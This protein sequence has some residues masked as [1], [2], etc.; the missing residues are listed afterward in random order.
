MKDENELVE[1]KSPDLA[2][3]EFELQAFPVPLQW[4]G[5]SKTLTWSREPE[6]PPDQKILWNEMLAFHRRMIMDHVG[7]HI[8][9][10][11]AVER[12]FHADPQ[13]NEK[14]VRVIKNHVTWIEKDANW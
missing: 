7:T 2:T 12:A 14:G 1:V 3:V 8:P 4:D 6:I 10:A 9:A 5:A 13:I 11:T